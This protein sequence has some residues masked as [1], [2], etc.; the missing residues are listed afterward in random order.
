MVGEVSSQHVYRNVSLK[1]SFLFIPNI[2]AIAYHK[3]NQKP[4][5][6]ET[7][8]KQNKKKLTKLTSYL[9]KYIEPCIKKTQSHFCL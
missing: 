1:Q 7:K 9:L 3:I 2:L 8:T 4:K 6:K 5:N